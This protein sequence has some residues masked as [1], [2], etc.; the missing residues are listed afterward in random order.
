VLLPGLMGIETNKKLMVLEGR[1]GVRMPTPQ[2]EGGA[3]KPH[4]CPGAFPGL[5]GIDS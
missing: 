3:S 2:K 1:L 5:T 4:T